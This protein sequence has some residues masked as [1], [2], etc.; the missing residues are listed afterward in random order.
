[1]SLARRYSRLPAPGAMLKLVQASEAALEESALDFYEKS[2][3]TWRSQYT[4]PSLARLGIGTEFLPAK[5]KRHKSSTNGDTESEN[6]QNGLQSATSALF[7]GKRS[8][9]PAL[10]SNVPVQVQC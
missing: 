5:S 10:S 3:L 8:L 7:N 4:N 6:Q 2:N 1:M 9:P